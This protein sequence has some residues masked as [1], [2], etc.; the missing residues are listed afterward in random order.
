[1]S[2][3]SIA[4]RRTVG[5]LPSNLVDHNYYYHHVTTLFTIV[6]CTLFNINPWAEP[7]LQQAR[8]VTERGMS[9]RGR[10]T[11]GAAKVWF[12]TEE[13]MYICTIN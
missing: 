3:L 13:I 10:H 4:N 12:S 6:T 2:Y 1:M 7:N 9:S 8:H 5:E 11:V